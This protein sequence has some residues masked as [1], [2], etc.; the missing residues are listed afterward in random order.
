LVGNLTV[1]EADK[2]QEQ[3]ERLARKLAARYDLDLIDIPVLPHE[4]V[5]G[6]RDGS[7]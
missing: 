2:V 4:I 7:L 5:Q 6:V 1:D 3:E